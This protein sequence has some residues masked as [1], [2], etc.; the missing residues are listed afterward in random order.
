M[1]MKPRLGMEMRQHLVI[2]Q[3]VQLML[4]FLQIPTLELQ[5]VLHQEILTN[6]VLELEDE[7]P[8]VDEKPKPEEGEGENPSTPTAA[9]EEEFATASKPE[10]EPQ[11]PEW[12]DFCN[13][14]YDPAF[15]RGETEETEFLERVPVAGTTLQ[16][17]LREQMRLLLHGEREEQL[18]EYLIGMID[19]RGYLVASDEEIMKETGATPEEVAAL[20][21]KLQSSDDQ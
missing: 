12:S 10:Q 1:E 3:K 17:S 9:T 2:T 11:E 16:E 21:Q 15:T 5:Q 7:D 6:P 20:V 4:K 8:I 18:V 19:E 14:E 13:E